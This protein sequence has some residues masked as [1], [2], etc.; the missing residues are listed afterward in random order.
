MNLEYGGEAGLLVAQAVEFKQIYDASRGISEPVNIPDNTWAGMG[1]ALRA[2]YDQGA[3][4]WVF[5]SDPPVL[6]ATI[7]GRMK[8]FI[9]LEQRLP[10]GE[11]V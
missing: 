2:A 5:S 10:S 7:P 4:I 1:S 11:S 6:T 8:V 9:K 3:Y